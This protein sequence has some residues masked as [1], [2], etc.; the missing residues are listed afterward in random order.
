MNVVPEHNRP[1]DLSKQGIPDQLYLL[2]RQAKDTDTEFDNRT[3][4]YT[5]KGYHFKDINSSFRNLLLSCLKIPLKI[6]P[7]LFRLKP[8]F[9]KDLK[10]HLKFELKANLHFF[11]LFCFDLFRRSEGCQ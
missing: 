9:I 11:I 3:W 1:M 6:S 2:T 10:L 8:M 5:F 4:V 7:K